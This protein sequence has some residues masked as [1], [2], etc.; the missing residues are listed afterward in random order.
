MTDLGKN[1]YSWTGYTEPFIVPAGVTITAVQI[2][3]QNLG[4][5]GLLGAV[6]IEYTVNRNSGLYVRA[7]NTTSTSVSFFSKDINFDTRMEYTSERFVINVDGEIVI[8]ETVVYDNVTEKYTI[9]LSATVDAEAGKAYRVI[10]KMV[11]VGTVHAT[12]V[13]TAGQKVIEPY[14]HIA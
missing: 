10:A 9:T 8:V 13:Y 1:G 5:T 12:A 7:L 4:V 2:S 3:T 6:P 11:D 14:P